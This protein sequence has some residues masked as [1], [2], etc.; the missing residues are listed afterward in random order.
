MSPRRTPM[1]VPYCPQQLGCC[2]VAAR[3]STYLSGRTGGLGAVPKFKRD[4]QETAP[5]HVKG[6]GTKIGGFE[7][8]R[9][10]GFV[11]FLVDLQNRF[12]TL[13]N[14]HKRVL[15]KRHAPH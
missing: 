11:C 8:P 6:V 13:E 10:R 4:A 15:N 1:I 2:C 12:G 7:S 14:H 5:D 3:A 9:L